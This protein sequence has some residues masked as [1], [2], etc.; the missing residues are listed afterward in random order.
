MLDRIDNYPTDETLIY[1]ESVSGN[2]HPDNYVGVGESKVG[3]IL[4]S[5]GFGPC[6]AVLAIL[7]N[8]EYGIYHAFSGFKT[9][10]LMKFMN[11]INGIAKDV[12]VFQKSHPQ[13]NL[14][15]APYLTLELARE[16]N[17]KVKRLH[18]DDHTG[19][20]VNGNTGKIVL[21]SQPTYTRTNDQTSI[22][23]SGEPKS[24]PLDKHISLEATIDEIIEKHASDDDYKL[25]SNML[26]VKTVV[27]PEK[28]LPSD[29]YKRIKGKSEVYNANMN[30]FNPPKKS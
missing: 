3:K 18:I 8:G 4:V 21:F 27:I 12:F 28:F 16:L 20:C 7:D 2:V 15:K 29:L 23:L 24:I 6:Q 10:S 1:C 30:G 14:L 9:T 22:V 26:V 5:D 25:H 19:I 13:P 11:S 17:C